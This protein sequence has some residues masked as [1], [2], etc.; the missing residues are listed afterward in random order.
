ML[1]KPVAVFKTLYKIELFKQSLDNQTKLNY[2][3]CE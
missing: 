2:H 1:S 3:L